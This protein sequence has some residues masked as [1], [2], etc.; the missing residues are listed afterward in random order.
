MEIA[1]F[2]ITAAQGGEYDETFTFYEDEAKTVPKDLGVKGW[3]GR[4]VM[5]DKKRE[6][7]PVIST[8]IDTSRADVGEIRVKIP[9]GVT[10]AMRSLNHE[11]DALVPVY[12]YVYAVI[13]ENGDRAKWIMRGDLALIPDPAR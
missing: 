5:R 11:E 6:F 10:A 2:N 4:I 7:E 9:S 8:E 3:S 13:C 12:N 1:V